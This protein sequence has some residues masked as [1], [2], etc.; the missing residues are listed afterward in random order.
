MFLNLENLI[1]N[2][3]EYARHYIR[4]SIS[5]KFIGNIKIHKFL[6]FIIQN[7]IL[8]NNDLNDYK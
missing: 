8:K 6:Y 3:I 5:N 1:L 2:S 7:I 4:H